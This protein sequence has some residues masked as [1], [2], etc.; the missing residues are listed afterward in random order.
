MNVPRLVRVSVRVIAE[1]DGLTASHSLPT[2]YLDRDELG[3]INRDQALLIVMSII[4]PCK[5]G[6][7]SAE[8]DFDLWPTPN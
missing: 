2:F 7:Y 4:D 8:I 6:A 3:L 1:A 5:S